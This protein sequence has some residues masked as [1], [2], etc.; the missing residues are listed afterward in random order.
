[1]CAH[2]PQDN[3]LQQAAAAAASKVFDALVLL[4]LIP[5]PLPVRMECCE[6]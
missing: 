1:M 5:V 6:C 4:V 2:S 3:G